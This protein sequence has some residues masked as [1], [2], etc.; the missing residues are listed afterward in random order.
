MGRYQCQECLRVFAR[1]DSLRRHKS[2]G[3]CKA[4]TTIFDTEDSNLSD[5]QESSRD[6]KPTS[7]LKRKDIFGKYDDTE[8]KDGSEAAE[9]DMET[10]EDI[11]QRKHDP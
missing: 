1:A 8:S 10:D 3:V 4:A 11:H 9:F 5:A 2:S 7:D 6:K